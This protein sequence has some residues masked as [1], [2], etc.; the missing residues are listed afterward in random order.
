MILD[1]L[2]AYKHPEK[3]AQGVAPG[4]TSK[5]LIIWVFSKQL[6]QRLVYLDVFT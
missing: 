2:E 3:F 6:D 4:V 5:E 1:L